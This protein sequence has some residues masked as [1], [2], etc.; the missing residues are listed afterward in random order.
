MA[1]TNPQ[2]PNCVNCNKSGLAI[3][4]VRYAVVPNHV[5]ATLPA[6]LGNKVSDVK[7]GQHKYALRA[8]RQGYI[9]VFHEKHPRGSQ[10]TW[11]VYSVTEAGTLWKQLSPSAIT[12]ALEEPSCSRS[13][14]NIPASVI[15]IEA[16]EK[17]KRV[18]IAFSEHA[19]S[20]E[21]FKDFASDSKLRDRR[22]QT[23][24]PA[25]WITAGGYRHGLPATQANIEQVLEYKPGFN[26]ASLNGAALP[27]ISEASGVHKQ[28]RL[29]MQSTRYKAVARTN[30]SEPLVK[31]MQQ[32]SQNKGKDHPPVMIALWDAVGI[33]HELNGFRNDT[34]GW[35][36]KYN[37]ERDQQVSAMMSIV[38]LK[39]ALAKRAGDSVDDFQKQA[40]DNSTFKGDTQQRRLNAAKLPPDQRARELEVCNIFDDWKAR[41]V[42]TSL[43]AMRLNEANFMKEPQRSIEIGRIKQEANDMLARRDKN[44]AQNIDDARNG[45]WGRYEDQL[46]DAGPGQKQYQ[47]FKERYDT[48]LTAVDKLMNERTVD[49]VAWLESKYLIN[50]FTEFHGNSVED[51]IVFDDQIGCAV[52]GINSSQSGQAKLDAWV[53]EIKATETNLLWRAIALNQT[54]GMQEIT[55]FLQEVQKHAEE[56]TPGGKLDWTTTV[57][58]TLKAFVDTHKKFA[59]MNS[60][61]TDAA[62]AS[63]SKAFGIKLKSINARGSDLLMM[64][65]GD[66][67]FGQF[68][69]FGLADFAAEKMM[70]YVF[71]I[72]AL[73]P[74]TVAVELIRAQ[75]AGDPQLRHQQL[76]ELRASRSLVAQGTPPKITKET[77]TL[78]SAWEK[79]RQTSAKAPNAMRDSRLAILI[80]LIEGVNFGKLLSDCIEKNDAKSWWSLAASSMT[81]S[82]ALFDVASVGVKAIAKGGGDNLTYQQL[83]LYGGVLSSAAAAITVGLDSKASLTKIAQGEKVLAGLYAAK[84]FIGFGGVAITAATT[85]TY[86]AP[87]I[88]RLTGSAAASG[89]AKVVGERAVALIATR[90]L[91]MSAGG[92]IT[93]AGFGIQILIW[94]FNK[95]DL[96]IWCGLCVF[97]KNT[98][99]KDSYKSTKEQMLALEKVLVNMGMAEAKPKSKAEIESD[100]KKILAM[101]RP[102]IEEMQLHD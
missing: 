1:C 77:A 16:P 17:C 26:P 10:I 51:G 23:F 81:I 94:I 88:L 80:M 57:P 68:R 29:A 14:H 27:A 32:I 85:F 37:A 54:E 89:A 28:S 6:P 66:K 60:S 86:S 9:Y 12:P 11:E 59:S 64:T 67:I 21:T 7:L 18:W 90:I 83:K 39:Q 96:Q 87:I 69:L 15:T 50:A 78:Q 55:A 82:S 34:A 102:T 41:K 36:E 3:L 40:I 98:D 13:G 4:P 38:G 52:F 46:A 48:F 73:V 93:V 43:F 97:G 33:T 53:K 22:M 45:A 44:A 74:S 91:F 47:V 58:K 71:S 76:Q 19:W 75:V 20:A 100:T 70:Q 61:N 30:Q 31:L 65:V 79:F 25:T 101:P 99:A 95:D 62:S 8:L 92:W 56:K 63:G 84:A 24:L 5:D 49:L 72:R 2:N 42:P 35:V